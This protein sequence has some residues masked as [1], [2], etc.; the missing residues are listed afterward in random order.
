[1]SDEVGEMAVST[2]KSQM[3]LFEIEGMRSEIIMKFTMKLDMQLVALSRRDFGCGW[4][5]FGGSWV[6]KV[7]RLIEE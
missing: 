7:D 4:V 1:M 6:D 5:G 2:L 3:I